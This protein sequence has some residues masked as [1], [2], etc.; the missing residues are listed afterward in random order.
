MN[1]ADVGIVF[2]ITTS[3]MTGGGVAADYY[4]Q[5]E[6]VPVSALLERDARELRGEIRGLEYDQDH[7]GLSDKEE[8]LLDQLR[9]DLEDVEGQLK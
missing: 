1:I 3:L 4:L 2:G 9:E 7:G 5:H 6:Y 8:W